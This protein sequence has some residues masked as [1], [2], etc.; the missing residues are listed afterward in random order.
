MK[1]SN[2][3][4]YTR[5]TMVIIFPELIIKIAE[6]EGHTKCPN[7]LEVN[8]KVWLVGNQRDRF[9]INL[10]RPVSACLLILQAK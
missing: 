10:I 6:T 9:L 5:Q 8:G 1:K 7:L 3:A 2:Q 4:E